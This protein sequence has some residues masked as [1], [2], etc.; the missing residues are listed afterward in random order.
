MNDAHVEKKSRDEREGKKEEE[1]DNVVLLRL[2]NKNEY[3]SVL[4][5]H[6]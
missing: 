4:C 3:S 6:I 5:F 1:E 2:G